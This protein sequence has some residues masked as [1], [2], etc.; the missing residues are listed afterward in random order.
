MK[1]EITNIFHI[2]CFC[3][4]YSQI[5]DTL[6]NTIESDVVWAICRDREWSCYIWRICCDNQ[7]IRSTGLKINDKFE[8]MIIAAFIILWQKILRWIERIKRVIVEIAVYIDITLAWK[9]IKS[10]CDHVQLDSFKIK[11]WSSTISRIHLTTLCERWCVHWFDDWWG[12][13]S[14]KNKNKTK[15]LAL[16]NEFK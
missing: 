5:I 6:T 11:V 1:I 3:A 10:S 16:L 7:Y 8:L 9:T 13:Y 4:N 12:A 2:F 15:F 14:K